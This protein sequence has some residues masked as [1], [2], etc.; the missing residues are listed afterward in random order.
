MLVVTLT[1]AMPFPQ[2]ASFGLFGNNYYN[3]YGAAAAVVGYNSGY[4][5]YD[6]Y[7][8]YGYDTNDYYSINILYNDF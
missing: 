8:N 7:G 4:N 1:A 6:N 2:V 3:N 5:N